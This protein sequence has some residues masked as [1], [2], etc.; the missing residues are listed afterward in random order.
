ML[1]ISNQPIN[2]LLLWNGGGDA[3][4]KVIIMMIEVTEY[5]GIFWVG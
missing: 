3:E 1:C 2:N 4:R 5:F